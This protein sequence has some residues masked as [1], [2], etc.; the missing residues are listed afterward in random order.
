MLLYSHHVSQYVIIGPAAYRK[1]VFIQISHMMWGCLHTNPIMT[2]F[3][4]SWHFYFDPECVFWPFV[5]RLKR[6][7]TLFSLEA[8]TD[9]NHFNISLDSGKK[10]CYCLCR[11]CTIF[12]SLCSVSVAENSFPYLLCL[13]ISLY[14]LQW[15]LSHN[16]CSP[17]SKHFDRHFKEGLTSFP[18]DSAGLTTIFCSSCTNLVSPD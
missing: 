11:S 2:H 7:K 12:S 5:F 16:C 10:W 15:H 18:L 13:L 6:V 1:S 9:I 3:T 4:N 8:L 14:L 17:N